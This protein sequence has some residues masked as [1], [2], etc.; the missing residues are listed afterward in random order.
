MV[1]RIIDRMGWAIAGALAITLVASLAGVLHAG[2]L[3]P[4]NGVTPS[5]STGRTQILGLPYTISAPGSYVVS[6]DLVGQSSS[7]GITIT[8]GNVTLDLSGFAVRGVP[9]SFD[10]VNV[11]CTCTSIVVENGAISG[12]GGNGL[13]F[14]PSSSSSAANVQVTN[15]AGIGIVLGSSNQARDCAVGSNGGGGVGAVSGTAVRNCAIGG[16]PSAHGV[17]ITG[18][19]NDVSENRIADVIDGIRVLEDANR[20]EHN[21]IGGSFCTT[22]IHLVSNHDG[23]TVQRNQVIGCGTGIA[24]E[25]GA[26]GN[27]FLENVVSGSTSTGIAIGN[28]TIAAWPNVV[29]KNVVNVSGTNYSISTTNNSAAPIA[30]AAV[31][32]NPF[33][34]LSN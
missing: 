31:A 26:F 30:S 15:N 5:T 28:G 21:Q 1:A 34:N 13:D 2:P 12:W 14:G 25:P 16:S 7:D 18:S 8:S 20:I 11:T 22:G 4:P 29:A 9:G 33:T 23:N 27:R 3:D 32:T 19:F 6:R 10:G 24:M 17:M